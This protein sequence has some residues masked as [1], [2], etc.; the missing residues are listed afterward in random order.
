M[1]LAHCARSDA[2]V[3]L[4]LHGDMSC[5]G[6]GELLWSACIQAPGQ[7]PLVVF[8]MP[9]FPQVMD[10]ADKKAL[11]LKTLVMVTTGACARFTDAAILMEILF[12]VKGLLIDGTAGP[13]AVASTKQSMYQHHRL[14]LSPDATGL[15]LAVA[16]T[17]HRACW[18]ALLALHSTVGDL[19]HMNPGAPSAVAPPLPSNRPCC[20]CS[21]ADAQGEHPLHAAP[22]SN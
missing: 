10:H 8:L 13:S 21:G 22:G 3:R 4:C 14:M 12:I 6:C 9:P 7:A 15:P 16:S 2:P 5:S 20:L 19:R 11:L 18:A 1:N 17:C